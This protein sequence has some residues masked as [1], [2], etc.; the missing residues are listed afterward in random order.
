MLN[1]G[2]QPLNMCGF[3][4]AEYFLTHGWESGYRFAGGFQV[5]WLVRCQF[6]F[7]HL[8]LPDMPCPPTC[9]VLVE[10]VK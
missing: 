8:P 10:C 1:I 7:C 4:L 6:L 9:E 5:T 3:L 2:K